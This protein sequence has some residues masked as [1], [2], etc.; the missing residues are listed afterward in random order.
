MA[1]N[2]NELFANQIDNASPPLLTLYD[3]ILASSELRRSMTDIFGEGHVDAA[4]ASCRTC[5]TPVKKSLR[6]RIAGAPLGPPRTTSGWKKHLCQLGSTC[7]N[8]CDSLVTC[9]IHCDPR[10]L[11]MQPTTPNENKSY[12]KF[13]LRIKAGL[14]DRYPLIDL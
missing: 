5:R 3:A 12:A 7:R 14:D 9:H 13:V 2:D 10:A 1:V 4:N 8:W 6:H 11:L